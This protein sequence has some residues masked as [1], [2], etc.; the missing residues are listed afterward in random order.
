[1]KNLKQHFFYY[2]SLVIVVLFGFSLAFLMY[3]N[4][5]LGFLFAIITVIFYILFGIIHHRMNHE[6]STKIVV[7]YVLIGTLGL[8]I[9]FLVLKGA[10]GM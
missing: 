8:G 6:L 3:P 5:N 9:I 4:L 7:E 1:M 2:L 10:L